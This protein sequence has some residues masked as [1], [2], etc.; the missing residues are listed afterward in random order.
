MDAHAEKGHP[1]GFNSKLMTTQHVWRDSNAQCDSK[2]ILSALRFA[3]TLRVWADVAMLPCEIPEDE[4]QL[5]SAF[6][7]TDAL[8]SLHNSSRNI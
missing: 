1:R 2:G 4:N 8:F 5:S 7:T 6:A 3:A